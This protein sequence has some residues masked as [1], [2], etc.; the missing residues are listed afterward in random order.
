MRHFAVLGHPVAQS[1]S[2]VMH[3]ASFQAIGYPG[4]YVKLDVSPETLPAALADLASRGF[5]GLNLTIPLKET[6]LRLMTSLTPEA[7]RAGAVNTVRI[8]PGGA[9]A[10]HNT[11]GA[12]CLEAI[13]TEL[14]VD[15]ANATACIVGCGGAGKAIAF[16]LGCA[17]ARLLLVNRTRERAEQ[18]AEKLRRLGI[19]AAAAGDPLAAARASHLV[20][21]CTP[22]GLPGY[23]APA[24]PPE[25][26]YPGQAVYD[27]VIPPLA[28]LTPTLLAAQT[29]GARIAGGESML[30]CQGARSFT[31]WTGLQP[32]RAAMRRAVEAAL[33]AKRN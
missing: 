6:A 5:L 15:P 24:L 22:S 13:Q 7:A 32:D 30:V 31:F 29:S 12:G 10:G 26:F 20:V 16:A 27:T 33:A 28:P 3:T 14:G 4:D 19:E 11:D 1:F 18:L 25:A 21:Q 9:F 17:G 8:E 2:P 23:D